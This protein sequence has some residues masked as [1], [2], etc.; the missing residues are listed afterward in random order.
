MPFILLRYS[1][2]LNLYRSHDIVI[3][4]V[5]VDYSLGC[6]EKCTSVNPEFTSVSLEFTSVSLEF[7]SVSLEFTSV[8]VNI[9]KLKIKSLPQISAAKIMVAP[10]I[11]GQVG[12]GGGGSVRCDYKQ[13]WCVLLP[14]FYFLKEKGRK[15][16]KSVELTGNELGVGSKKGIKY[17]CVP[18]R[19]DIW[20]V[21]RQPTTGGSQGVEEG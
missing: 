21:D 2:L 14:L 19:Q 5:I 12:D 10:R 1:V 20:L 3:S 15:Y 8:R 6:D 7:T 17:A 9:R 4:L 16:F 13:A 18:V 11:G